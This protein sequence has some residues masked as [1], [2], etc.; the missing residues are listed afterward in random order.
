M[1]ASFRDKEL[2]DVKFIGIAGE[3]F[4]KDQEEWFEKLRVLFVRHGGTMLAHR[5]HGV[6]IQVGVTR[7]AASLLRLERT[8]GN[9]TGVLVFKQ[10]NFPD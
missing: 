6:L 5:F 10:V 2:L 4:T 7:Q 1:R 9:V 8:A 3:T